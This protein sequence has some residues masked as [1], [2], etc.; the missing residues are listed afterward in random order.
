MHKKVRESTD[1]FFICLFLED[2]AKRKTTTNW[3]TLMSVTHDWPKENPHWWQPRLTER[4]MP[5]T[6]PLTVT[7][8]NGPIVDRDFE[9]IS[10]WVSLGTPD[11][12]GKNRGHFT[13]N[14][15]QFTFTMRTRQKA[16]GGTMYRTCKTQSTEARE[17][18]GSRKYR[19]E[20]WLD[21]WSNFLVRLFL[22]WWSCALQFW[23]ELR[24]SKGCAV[25]RISKPISQIFS[26]FHVVEFSHET[27]SKASG[28]WGFKVGIVTGTQA[29]TSRLFPGP[30]VLL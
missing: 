29:A 13:T 26:T 28:N 17:G 22:S 7:T 30:T 24:A 10:I 3:V 19:L 16:V 9:E 1:W 27:I 4:T 5:A 12:V 21:L 23:V 2:Y 8:H 20:L 11:S 25:L 14:T 6:T 18:G 15:E